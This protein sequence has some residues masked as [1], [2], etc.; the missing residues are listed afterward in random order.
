MA[1]YL[2]AFLDLIRLKVAHYALTRLL[3]LA[4]IKC[5]LL[6]C[7]IG[8][9]RLFFLK[10]TR[11]YACGES[12]MT[13]GITTGR[14]PPAMECWHLPLLKSCVCFSSPLW[15]IIQPTRPHSSG[16]SVPNA[17]QSGLCSVFLRLLKV[18]SIR[19]FFSDRVWFGFHYDYAL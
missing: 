8:A 14:R 16:S 9:R 1:L 19:S 13:W 2:V 10:I 6:K 15:S 7:S 4:F 18:P 12:T 5:I 11:C 17:S 3:T